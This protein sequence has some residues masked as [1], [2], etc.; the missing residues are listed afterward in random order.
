M[1][2]FNCSPYILQA[3]RD[4]FP[5]TSSIA[6]TPEV[7]RAVQQAKEANHN[8]LIAQHRVSEVKEAAIIQQKIAL[9]REAAAREATKR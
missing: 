1:F 3:L 8:V 5:G 4:P 9:A 6:Y 2:A 7:L